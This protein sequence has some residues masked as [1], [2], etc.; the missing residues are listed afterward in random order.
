[1]TRLPPVRDE[2]LTP[3]QREVWDSLTES[4]GG[5]LRL[6]GPDGGLIGPFNAMVTNP[7]A[8]RPMA[9]LGAAIRFGGQIDNRLLELAIIVVGAH[10]RSNFEFWAHARLARAAGVGDDVID[11]VAEGVEPSFD[12][13]DER[14]VYGV[15]SQLMTTGQIDDETYRQAADLLEPDALVHL[16]MTIGY[17][18]LVSLTLN[19]FAVA[20]P[21]G[22]TPTWAD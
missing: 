8:G 9:E 21:E 15:A 5:S 17:Y 19:A 6:V 3:T 22:E 16:V 12:R 11:A 1:M 10:W 4:R 14:V 2:D 18:S 20:L 13:D 7:E